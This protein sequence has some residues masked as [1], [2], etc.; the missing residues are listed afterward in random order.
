[1]LALI[2][3]GVLPTALANGATL[4]EALA[5]AYGA[6]PR[7]EAARAA[8]RAADEGMP[9]ARAAGRPQLVSTTSAAVRIS[10]PASAVRAIRATGLATV[11]AAR[12]GVRQSL[13]RVERLLAGGEQELVP[14]IG[15]L[16]DLILAG[17]HDVSRSLPYAHSTSRGPETRMLPQAQAAGASHDEL[18]RTE[19]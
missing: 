15:T 1:M 2:L 6:N 5:T 13:R 18:K 10:A 12:G 3:S 4:A 9:Q 17:S 14:A 16:D 8:A 11:L 7:L 19:I